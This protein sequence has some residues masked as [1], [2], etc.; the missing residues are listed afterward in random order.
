MFKFEDTSVPSEDLDSRQKALALAA[1]G[2]AVFPCREKDEIER[3]IQRKRKSPYTARGFLDATTDPEIVSELF[4]KWPDA[5]VGYWCG[6]SSVDVLD[7][8]VKGIYSGQEELERRELDFT[9]TLSYSTPSGGVHVVFEADPSRPIRPT[10]NYMKL[11][12]VDIRAG[13][14][15][16]IFYG[17]VPLFR[18]FPVAPD[19][20]RSAKRGKQS[21]GQS[22]RSSNGVFSGDV[23][24][25]IDWLG[26]EE[27]FWSAKAI[28][29]EIS[30]LSHVGHNDLIR[31][32]VWIHQ[33]RLEGEASLQPMLKALVEKFQMTTNN[34]DWITELNSAVRWVIGPAWTP[35]D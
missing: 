22:L 9:S 30:C 33:T 14:S 16:A 1:L 6:E 31:M 29:Y 13:N 3:G 7:L 15:Y 28:A 24:T 4:T 21:S 5:F 10:V 19:W 26:N 17:K 32:L 18:D 12:C 27:P 8:D 35:K 11:Q 23:Q 25:W 20:M 2:F 34:P